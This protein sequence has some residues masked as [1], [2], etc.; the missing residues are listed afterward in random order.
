MKK[1]I[2]LLLVGLIGTHSIAHATVTP[3]THTIIA[4]LNSAKKYVFSTAILKDLAAAY[5]LGM[6]LTLVHEFG[7]AVFGLSLIHI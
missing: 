3:A 2:A 5:C 7:H 4:T 1:I 6:G